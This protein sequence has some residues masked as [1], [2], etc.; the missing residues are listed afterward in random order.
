M[1]TLTVLIN[2]HLF[3]LDSTYS[4]KVQDADLCYFTVE[5]TRYKHAVCEQ[6]FSVV[7]RTSEKIFRLLGFH[8]NIHIKL[9]IVIFCHVNFCEFIEASLFFSLGCLIFALDEMS[10]NKIWYRNYL[11]N[12]QYAYAESEDGYWDIWIIFRPINIV[13]CSRFPQHLLMFTQRLLS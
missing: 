8:S 6:T 4:S 2:F 12:L 5:F 7:L 11:L 1:F 10:K 9:S 3:Y 13:L